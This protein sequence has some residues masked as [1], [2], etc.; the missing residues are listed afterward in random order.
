[1]VAAI[2]AVRLMRCGSVAV[3]PVPLDAGLERSAARAVQRPPASCCWYCRCSA[4]RCRVP[5]VTQFR[6]SEDR[7]SCA[8]DTQVDLAEATGRRH[9]TLAWTLLGIAAL[10][11]CA[12]LWHRFVRRDAVLR[13]IV[14]G[15][16]QAGAPEAAPIHLPRESHHVIFVSIARRASLLAAAGLRPPLAAF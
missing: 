11:A 10:H 1:M 13:A 2:T 12:A 9:E 5:A 6:S 3:S 4:G 14:A 16:R 8:G 7:S 15:A